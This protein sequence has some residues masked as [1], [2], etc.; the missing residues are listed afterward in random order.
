MCFV[1][2]F[3]FV[4]LFCVFFVC[5]FFMFVWFFVVILGWGLLLCFFS[6]FLCVS[7]L[8]V[9]WFSANNCISKVF[10][11]TGSKRPNGPICCLVW[12]CI[13]ESLAGV[14]EIY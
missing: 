5:L 14:V 11:A 2:L 13:Y 9:C 4:C 6:L 8:C 3:L 10:C 12:E 7:F 1:Y